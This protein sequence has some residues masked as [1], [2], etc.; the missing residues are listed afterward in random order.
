MNGRSV[1]ECAVMGNFSFI[2]WDRI[3]AIVD[4][5]LRHLGFRVT[6]DQEERENM[7]RLSLAMHFAL[8]RSAL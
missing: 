6:P 7:R 4:L 5:G 8:C 3:V 1:L 2:L